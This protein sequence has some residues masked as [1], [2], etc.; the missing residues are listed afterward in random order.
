[1]GLSIAVAGAVIMMAFLFSMPALYSGVEQIFSGSVTSSEINEVNDSI[2][3]TDFKIRTLDACSG[4]TPSL[5][6][7]GL[8]NTGNEK[9]SDFGEFDV[10][11]TYDADIA[12]VKT[13]VTEQFTYNGTAFSISQ[14]LATNA[15]EIP[16][17]YVEVV[18]SLQT[19]NPTYNDLPGANL[20]N[21]NFDINKKYLIYVTA[22]VG[23][24]DSGEHYGIRA[25]HGS[26]A[27]PGSEFLVEPVTSATYHNY[28]WFTV[29]NPT[30]AVEASEDIKLQYKRHTGGGS[31]R[32]RFNQVTMFAMEISEDLTENTDWF[33]DDDESSTLLPTDPAW[34]AVNNAAVTFTPD[35]PKDT[36]L[37]MATAQLQPQE[38]TEQYE[39]RLFATGSGDT[40]SVEMISKED[41][42]TL[43]DNLY[44]E[45]IVYTYTI[46]AVSTTFESQSRTDG[47]PA[48][49][50]REYSAVFA[51]NLDKFMSQKS[52]SSPEVRD[53]GLSPDW[54]TQVQ[55][56]SFTP[57]EAGDVWVL[58]YFISD[59]STNSGGTASIHARMQV[60]ETGKTQEDQPPTQTTDLL[61]QNRFWDNDGSHEWTIQTVEYFGPTSYT[62]DIDADVVGTITTIDAIYRV[63]SFVSMI[64]EECV[65][66][67]SGN[68][69][70]VNE[71]TINC[72]N[73][74]YLD[75]GLINTH[76]V[77]EVLLKTQYPIFPGGLLEVSISADNGETQVKSKLIP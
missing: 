32:G 6:K 41:E 31:D 47:D 4:R 54:V 25:V 13:R 24:S 27:F 50:T 17:V 5:V 77:A 11:A 70:E 42:G 76:E 61:Q 19:N 39:T 75:P 67:D 2:T 3:K 58:G 59:I 33:F 34:T 65:G 46:P 23:G 7:V 49:S 21:A 51:L 68:N 29:W 64:T 66:G 63:I 44:V 53:I 26:T 37:V 8:S 12:N 20:S 30:N 9:L 55:S 36:W 22:Q 74:D 73:N 1:M 52:I 69:F 56:L 18:S 35:C 60:Y 71:W 14:G 38:V 28:G 72:I 40:T 43:L 16:H 62:A 15:T 48:L 10:F 57:D 45:T